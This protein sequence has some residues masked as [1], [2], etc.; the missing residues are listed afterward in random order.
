VDVPVAFDNCV[1][2]M[3]RYT[4]VDDLPPLIEALEAGGL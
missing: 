2:D 3:A 1:P 4:G